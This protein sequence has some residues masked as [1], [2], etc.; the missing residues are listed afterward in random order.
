M[1]AKRPPALHDARIKIHYLRYFVV[2]AEE[3]HFG[4]AADRLAITQPPLSSALKA[5]EQLLDVRLLDRDSKHVRMTPAGA[6]F[7]IEAR[8]ILEQLER[9]GETARAVAGGLRGRLD[10]GIT[11]SSIYRDAPEIVDAFNQCM[12]GIEVTLRELS[13]SDQLDQLMHSQLDAGFVNA[14]TVPAGLVAHPLRDDVMV[15]CLPADHPLARHKAIDLSTLA[16]ETFIMAARDVAPANYDNVIAIFNRA[17]I[18]PRTRHATRQ[19]LTS[20]ALVSTGMGVALVPSSIARAGIAGVRYV[21]IKGP[22]NRAS[23][24]IVWNATNRK[25]ALEAFI[26]SARKHTQNP[27]PRLRVRSA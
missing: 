2:L 27:K 12:P 8:Q 1:T 10:I 24:Q 15:C 6:A 5:L 11:A 22:E 3:L 20:V 18:H 19:W 21:P 23:A 26:E 17:G 4:R 14:P 7:H 13:S 9:A 25:P 16:D